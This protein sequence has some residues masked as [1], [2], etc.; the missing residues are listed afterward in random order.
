MESNFYT[1]LA[2]GG[3]SEALVQAFLNTKG[4]D[5][6]DRTHDKE[7]QSI[8]IDFTVIKANDCRSI[9]VKQDNRVGDTGNL[10]IEIIT[11]KKSGN[12]GWFNKTQA[13]Y[14]VFHDTINKQLLIAETAE[15]RA[16]LNTKANCA[17]WKEWK[18]F[19][20]YGYKT[21]EGWLIP[22]ADY[23]NYYSLGEYS[24]GGEEQ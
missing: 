11:N 20:G 21:A 14:I 17:R 18:T 2:Q 13:E 9:E 16:Y 5:V 8:D 12:Q 6:T 23:K 22:I 1:T 3:K 19:E 15:L 4:W 24:I 7:Y 10:L